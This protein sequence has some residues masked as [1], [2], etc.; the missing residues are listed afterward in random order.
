MKFTLQNNLLVP[1]PLAKNKDYHKKLSE[2]PIPP[3]PLPN[4]TFPYAKALQLFLSGRALLLDEI[5]F[6]LTQLHNHY[7]NGYISYTIGLTTTPNPHC[8][9]CGNAKPHLFAKF[10][11]HRCQATCTYCRNCIMMG[12][13]SECTPLIKWTGPQPLPSQQLEPLYWNGTLSEGQQT[14]SEKVIEAVHNNS[15]LL[16]W[17]VCGAGKTEVLFQ[18]INEAL[19]NN[20]RVCIATPRTDVVLELAPRLQKVFPATLLSTQY[21]GSEQRHEYRQLVLST[22]H[23]LYRY[24]EAFDVLIVDEVDAFPFSYDASLQF[25]VQQA[26]KPESALIHLTATPDKKTQQQC[27]K[28]QQNY[29]TIPARFHR[30]PIPQPTL[31]WCGNW[32]RS[33]EKGKL[34]LQIKKWTEQRLHQQKQ[35]LIF[36]PNI[37]TME[38]ALPLFQ[39]LHP[40]IESVHSEDSDRKEKVQDMRNQKTPILLTTTILERGVTFPDIDVAVLGAEDEVFTE[41]ALVQ[42]AGRVGRSAQHPTGDISFYHFGRTKQMINALLHIEKMNKEAEKRGLI[43]G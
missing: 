25:A 12:R 26:R 19:K 43:D 2:L 28:G 38:K 30:H 14:A 33:I 18:G 10:H 23:Q 40:N 20:K 37:K 36:L 42:I 41:S 22:T 8:Y 1:Q 29:I 6:N 5:P 21:G 11:C 32:K 4:Q 13:V 9:R 7:K 15:S 16:V 24:K 39:K 3:A 34:P 31:K 35:A 27:K 17:A